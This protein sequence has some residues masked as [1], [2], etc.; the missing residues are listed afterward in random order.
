MRRTIEENYVIIL[1]GIWAPYGALCSLRVNLSPSDLANIEEFTRENVSNWLTSH[2]GDFSSI[3]GFY[4]TAGNT[5]LDWE[6]E[7]LESAYLDTL[8]ELEEV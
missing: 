7:E 4:A 6:S 1:G 2:S 8:N 3:K 5:T